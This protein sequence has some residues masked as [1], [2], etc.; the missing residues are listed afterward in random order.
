MRVGC[1]FVEN[2]V[3]RLEHGTEMHRTGVPSPEAVETAVQQGP[4]G[5]VNELCLR[6]RCVA[7]RAYIRQLAES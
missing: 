1:E 7:R 4:F 3:L 6:F 5:S 2:M